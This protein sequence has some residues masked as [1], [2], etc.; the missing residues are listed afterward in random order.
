MI[1]RGFWYK[2]EQSSFQKRLQKKIMG[3]S[4]FSGSFF[5]RNNKRN[6]ITNNVL[7]LTRRFIFFNSLFRESWQLQTG[8]KLEYIIRLSY[9]PPE[10]VPQC[11]SPHTQQPEQSLDIWAIINERILQRK[12][13][14]TD[15]AVTHWIHH[16]HP[17]SLLFIFHA[18]LSG[19]ALKRG[20]Y[21]V[22]GRV[23]IIVA[24]IHIKNPVNTLY[25]KFLIF[26]SL[27]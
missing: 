1:W 15:Y 14:G 4:L 7:L 17:I 6:D 3:S 26:F 27:L 19:F 16:S 18:L 23:G 22:S 5:V 12:C 21:R 9:P 25:T 20:V 8:S 10:H 13:E 24:P 11:T 2:A